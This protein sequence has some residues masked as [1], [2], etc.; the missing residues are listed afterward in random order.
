MQ[1]KNAAA[2]EQ[3]CWQMRMADYARDVN[4]ARIN[5]LANG[6][7][8]YS[9][10]DVLKNAVEVNVND[11]SLTRLAHD[12]RSQLTQAFTKPGNFYS[13]KLDAGKVSKRQERSVTAT[14]EVTRIM[15]RSNP[16]FEC[17][18]STIALD[19]LHGIGPANWENEDRWKPIPLGVE[20][21]FVPSNTLLTFENL[22]FICIYRPYTANQLKRLTRNRRQAAEAGW[23]VEAVDKA[24]KWADE[25]SAKLYGSS[26]GNDYWSP[27]RQVERMKEDSGIYA[28][29]L[30]ATID[31][32]DFYYLDDAKRSEGWRRRIIFDAEGGYKMWHGDSSYGATSTRPGKNLLG[33]SKSDFVFSSGD[34]VVASKLEEIVHFQ[35]ADLSAVGPFRYHS[36]R[37]LGWL[38]YAAC[39]LQNRL[40]CA[41]SE[42][43]FENMMMY[44][45]VNSE[46]EAAEAL[47]LKL[48]NRGIIDRSTQFVP[49]SERWQPN[50]QLAELGLQEFKQIIADNSSSYTQNQNFSRDRVEKTRY[51]VMAEVNA[52][53]QMVSAGLQQAYRYQ[54]FQ[55]QEIFRR[56]MRKGSTDPDVNEF[57]ARCLSR[58]IPEKYLVADAWDI[59]PE[60]ILG[61]GNRTLEM[62][63]AQQLWEMR[64]AFSPESQQK[65]HRDVVLAITEDAARA[66]DLVPPVPSISNDR[67]DAMASYGSLMA[68]ARVELTSAQNRLEVAQTWIAEL[69]M[70]IQQATQMGNMASPDK[71]A[72]FANV[73]DHVS[74]LIG[75][76]SRDDAQKETAKRLADISGKLANAVKGF[77]QRIAEQQQAGG[78][79]DGGEQAKLVASLKAQLIQAEAKASNAKE[80]HAQRTA[81][82]QVT[83]EQQQKQA[84]EK[85]QLEM[86]RA[87]EQ[88]QVNDSVAVVSAA[89]EAKRKANEPSKPT[90]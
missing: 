57:Q 4:R 83:F 68:G 78:E 67:H 27:S 48:A 45:R 46:D 60:R 86:R 51:Q 53:Q 85:H 2:V 11:L 25:Q 35:F 42:A 81:Q 39:H 55:Y 22:P 56:F 1:F 37:S 20:D 75:E 89:G 9:D 8:P 64:S 52:M 6:A 88:A 15:K 73:L 62:A 13:A 87:V 71:V 80:S 63:I 40:R 38:L 44:L 31:C 43:V 32:L 7:P 33:E 50:Y 72:G 76:I 34:R 5:D 41:F 58:D 47:T 61:G 10:D 30:V 14:K 3:V 26:N 54:Q 66:N 17:M 70:G 69:A 90:D 19:V 18:R 16:Y 59:E 65:I 77:A 82:K 24:I 21:V 84:E 36:V 12:A 74:Q 29:D 49:P 28:S 79:G 23:N